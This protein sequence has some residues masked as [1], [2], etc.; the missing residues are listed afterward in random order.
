MIIQFVVFF[1]KHLK[2]SDCNLAEND[3]KTVYTSKI[4][5]YR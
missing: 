5:G 4:V 3:P 2:F 1:H